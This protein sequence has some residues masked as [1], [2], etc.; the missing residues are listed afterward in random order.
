MVIPALL[1]KLGLL[2]GGTKGEVGQGLIQLW[3]AD[4]Q[5]GQRLRPHSSVYWRQ[6]PVDFISAKLCNNLFYS[7]Q[8]WDSTKNTVMAAATQ[9]TS[10]HTLVLLLLQARSTASGS[11]VMGL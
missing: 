5:M 11:S 4:C 7:C 10:P 2:L 1:A 8:E 9:H 6:T 3:V